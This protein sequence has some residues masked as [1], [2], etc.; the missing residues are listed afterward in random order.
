MSK[1]L[2]IS[3]RARLKAATT[4]NREQTV[5]SI[6]AV[7]NRPIC[8]YC[9]GVPQKARKRAKTSQI[10][11][12]DRLLAAAD[13]LF[14]RE[15]VRAV[16]IDRVLAEADAAKASLYQHFGCKDQ[17]VASYL[18]RRT[19]DARANIEAYLADTPPSQRALK[20]FD[21]VVEWAKDFR[22]CPLQH[23]V[24]E[25]TDAAHPARAIAH[26]QREWFTERFLEWSTAAG[27][28]DA[29]A[30]ARALVV[31]FDGAVAGSEIDGPQR[32]IDARW[33]AR[34]LLAG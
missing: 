5:L 26:G 21:W 22:G 8:L 34:K 12:R 25:L 14:Y 7:D 2:T 27:V 4:Q 10:G 15:G 13:R 11:V 6:H 1:L 23:T 24:T 32:A 19:V 30:T 18:E 9:Q 33:M 16:G 31:L 28:K 20:F 29:N 17:L 3:Q